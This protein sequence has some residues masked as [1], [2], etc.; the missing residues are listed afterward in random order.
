MN[1]TSFYLEKGFIETAIGCAPNE[2]LMLG[3]D[4]QGTRK[5][6][7]LQHCAAGTTHIIMGDTLRCLATTL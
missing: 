4:A 2:V 5:H 6:N 7:G 3:S 1:Q